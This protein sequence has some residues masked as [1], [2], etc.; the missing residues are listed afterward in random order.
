MCLILNISVTIS[1]NQK[2]S[3]RIHILFFTALQL[4]YPLFPVCFQMLLPLFLCYSAFMFFISSSSSHCL[5]SSH[6]LSCFLLFYTLLL[7]F[8][9]TEGKPVWQ[10][11]MSQQK[12]FFLCSHTDTHSHTPSPLSCM[13]LLILPC[14]FSIKHN[15]CLG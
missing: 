13:P 1:Q 6:L 3:E 7:C 11:V 2:K 10:E 4:L 12:C 5:F 9:L 15:L 8:N 14:R